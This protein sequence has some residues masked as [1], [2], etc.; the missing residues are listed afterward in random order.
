MVVRVSDVVKLKYM[1]EI[2]IYPNGKSYEKIFPIGKAQHV[3]RTD[4]KDKSEKVRKEQQS[5]IESNK[6]EFK[7]NNSE[8]FL[9]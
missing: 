8:D 7:D 5:L 3:R 6:V 1:V 9:F 4:A 2:T